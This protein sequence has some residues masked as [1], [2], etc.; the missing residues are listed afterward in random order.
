V[1]LCK[2][3][4]SLALFFGLISSLTACKQTPKVNLEQTEAE[5]QQVLANQ[6]ELSIETGKLADQGQVEEALEKSAQLKANLARVLELNQIII[7]HIDE[8]KKELYIKRK[9]LFEI[10]IK[11]LNKMEECVAYL[12]DGKVAFEKCQTE[13]LEINQDLETKGKELQA[14]TE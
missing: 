14:L 7:N 13:F 9:E 8:D 10:N 6:E 5:I 2:I 11:L 3:I 12:A 4:L 1:N